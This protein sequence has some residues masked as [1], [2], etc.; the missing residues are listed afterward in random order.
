MIMKVWTGA[1]WHTVWVVKR[2]GI[3]FLGG[4]T[5]DIKYIRFSGNSIF[6][7]FRRGSQS[8]HAITNQFCRSIAKKSGYAEIVASITFRCSDVFI[9]VTEVKAITCTL[10]GI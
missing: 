5:F 3:N 6:F 2:Y 7:N 4:A 8:S 10:N 9:P 1:L